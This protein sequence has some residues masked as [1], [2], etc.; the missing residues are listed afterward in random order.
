[1]SFNRWDVSPAFDLLRQ[2]K[3]R[4]RGLI[5]R[6]NRQIVLLVKAGN[7]LLINGTVNT[8]NLS[9]GTLPPVDS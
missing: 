7:I 4:F 6:A 9:L 2:T 5:K 1:M 3:P 8:Y